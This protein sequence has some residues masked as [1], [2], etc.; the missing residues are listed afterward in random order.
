MDR[1]I[2]KIELSHFSGN[3]ELVVVID[4]IRVFT[5]A[6]YAFAKKAKQ[7]ILLEK[8]EEAYA[9]KCRYPDWW[10]IGEER[11]FLTPP[12]DLGNSPFEVFRAPLAGKTLIQRTSCG[13]LGAVRARHSQNILAASFVVAEA[14]LQRIKHLELKKTTLLITAPSPRGQEDWALADYLEAKLQ[15]GEV[16]SCYY[17]DQVRNSSDA[18]AFGTP[19]FPQ[20]DLDAICDL[21]RF[22]FAMEIFRDDPWLIL[23]PV[24]STGELFYP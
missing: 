1:L 10:L 15:V 24:T 22:S 9:L 2:E 21:N 4:V 23:R 16:D 5:T 13:T 14:T 11:G 6:A 18:K 3:R 17:L 12:F 8:M 7:I 19:G 20:E